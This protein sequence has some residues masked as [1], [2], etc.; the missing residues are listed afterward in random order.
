MK[1]HYRGLQAFC[2][3]LVEEEEVDRSPMAGMRA[4]AVP[5][6]PVPVF[7]DDELARLVKACHGREYAE[8]RDEA[9]MRMFIDTGVRIAEMAGI[10][11]DDLDTEHEARCRRWRRRWPPPDRCHPSGARHRPRRSGSARGWAPPRW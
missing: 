10:T 8:R 5:E 2:K 11:L 9:L 1:V 7:T 3:W 6:T 4:P